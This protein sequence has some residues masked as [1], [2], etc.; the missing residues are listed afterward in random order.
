AWAQSSTSALS[1]K[2]KIGVRPDFSGGCFQAGGNEERL[3][4]QG[5]PGV[6]Q[7][8]L[9]PLLGEHLGG[10]VLQR[11]A[12]FVQGAAAGIHRGELLDESDVFAVGLEVHGGKC[13]LSLFHHFPFEGSTISSAAM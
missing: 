13:K 9:A 4:H 8:G 12:R 6:R 1:V 10:Q 3:A 5:V 2:K 11:L 7:R